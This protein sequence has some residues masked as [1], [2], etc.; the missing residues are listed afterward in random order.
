MPKL[1]MSARTD[2][3]EADYQ[4][5]KEAKNLQPLSQVPPIKEW[6]HWK[7]IPNQFPYDGIFR[8]HN[9]LVPKRQFADRTQMRMTEWSELQGI[10]RDY[11]EKHYD[12]ILENT[13]KK[14]SVMSLYHIHVAN[15]YRTREE[16]AL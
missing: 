2:A 9:M 8:R 11:I 10:Y 14:R 12:L 6:K 3:S 15:Y 5:A 4:A 16:S 13:H 7:L 1:P